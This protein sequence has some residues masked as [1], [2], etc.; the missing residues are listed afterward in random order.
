MVVYGGL[1]WFMVVVVVCGSLWWFMV[2]CGGLW[3]F[4]GVCGDL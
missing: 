3:G 2:V 1:L 4:V